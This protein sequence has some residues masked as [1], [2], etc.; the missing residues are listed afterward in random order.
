MLLVGFVP[1]LRSDSFPSRYF[2]TFSLDWKLLAPMDRILRALSKL[3]VPQPSI[4]QEFLL[5]LI[6]IL[7]NTGLKLFLSIEV[8]PLRIKFLDLYVDL[9]SRAHISVVTQ[10][11]TLKPE[12]RS[13][14][15][16]YQSNPKSPL[17]HIILV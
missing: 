16:I 9:M 12:V 8:K 5:P 11:R 6:R 10:E 15:V 4:R 17:V 3:K 13:S 1:L 2:S 7:A 14:L